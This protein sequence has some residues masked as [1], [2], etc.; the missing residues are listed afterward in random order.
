MGLVENDRLIFELLHDEDVRILSDTRLR[1][2]GCERSLWKLKEEFGEK[3][4]RKRYPDK[5]IIVERTGEKLYEVWRKW[6][7]KFEK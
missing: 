3:I 2:L 1:R 4:G 7:T 6:A 5:R